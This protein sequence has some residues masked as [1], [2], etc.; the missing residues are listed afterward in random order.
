MSVSDATDPDMGQRDRVKF[1]LVRHPRFTNMSEA[2]IRRPQRVSPLPLDV[3]LTQSDRSEHGREAF[4]GG[5]TDEFNAFRKGV[6]ALAGGTVGGE[7]IIIQGAPGAGKTALM[8]ECAEAVCRHSTPQDP[9]VAVLLEPDI[10]ASATDTLSVIVE[11]V[12]VEKTR[13]AETISRTKAI[14]VKTARALE[15]TKK[16]VSERGFRAMGTQLGGKSSAR[17]TAA[18]LFRRAVP[19]LSGVCIVVLVDEAQDIPVGEHTKATI[20]RLHRGTDGIALLPLFFGLSN[21]ERVL[22]ECGVSRPGSERLWELRPMTLDESVESLTATFDAYGFGA[23]GAERNRWISA[24]AEESQ[25]WP[26]HLNRVAVAAGRIIRDNG[27]RLADASL[28]EAILAG[29]QLKDDYYE[30]RLGRAMSCPE[31]YKRL[32]LVAESEEGV[33]SRSAIKRLAAPTL[34]EYGMDVDAFLVASLHA[35]LLSPTTS[36]R[37]EYYFPIPSLAQFLRG[38]PIEPAA[39]PTGAE[40]DAMAP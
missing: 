30:K 37:Y 33:L 35:G 40:Y 8:L 19:D 10:L 22:G 27:F 1:G 3:W 12:V 36:G 20:D 38:L 14:A 2:K 23:P 13:L 11:Q 5:R 7:S 6:L 24:L 9:W 4:F 26:Q 16:E 29:R 28:D 25:G 18:W 21:T 34:K 32:A 31:L 17:H 39:V 15:R